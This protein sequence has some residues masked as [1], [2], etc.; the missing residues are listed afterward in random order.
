[1][2]C[3]RTATGCMRIGS[4]CARE[5]PGMSCCERRAGKTR[6]K[7]VG[8]GA[9]GEHGGEASPAGAAQPPPRIT[10]AWNPRTAHASSPILSGSERSTRQ[11]PMS[12]LLACIRHRRSAGTRGARRALH[13]SG[14]LPPCAPCAPCPH[15]RLL[16]F[17]VGGPVVPMDRDSSAARLGAVGGGGGPGVVGPGVLRVAALELPADFRVGAFPE[18]AQVL[19]DLHGFPTG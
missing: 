6:A 10:H 14:A 4:A 18:A 19:R 1:M 9:H 11:T 8:H 17:F 5:D 13:S 12:E 16:L 7:D 15:L 3:I 2:G